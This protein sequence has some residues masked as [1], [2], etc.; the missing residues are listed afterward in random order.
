MSSG[1]ISEE[2]ERQLV[3][4]VELRFALA[5]SGEKLEKSLD[6]FVAPLLLKLGSPHA[7]VRQ[8][9]FNALKDILARLNSLKEVKVPAERLI[10]QAQKPA[11]AAEQDDSSIRLY[12]LLLASRGIDRMGAEELKPLVPL[13]MGG[14][15]Q[16]PRTAAARM[17]HI[18]CKILLRWVPPLKGSREEDEAREFLRLEDENDLTFLLEKFTKFYLLVPA[19]PDSRSGTIP[20]GYSCPGLSSEDVSFLTYEAGVS[21]TKEQMLRFK[22]AIFK[23]I[24]NGFAPEDILLT[25]FLLVASADAS[26]ISESAAQCLK[27]IH[28]PYEDA[29]FV[30]SIVELYTGDKT[31]GVPPVK[32]E[33][34]E[35]I[36]RILT[37]SAQAT[38]DAS[39]VSLICSIGMH[40]QNHKTRALC[41]VF[42]RHVARHNYQNLTLKQEN[43]IS[44][45]PLIR[46]NLHEEGWPRLQLGQSTPNFSAAIDRRRLEYE[47]LGDILRRDVDLLP[48][49]SY[50]EFLLDS[51][52]GDL[53]EF[54]PSIQ[55]ALVSLTPNL[56]L[57]PATSKAKLKLLLRKMMMDDAEL[58]YADDKDMKE[59]IMSCRYVGIKYCNA[60]FPF[61]D[62]E[63]RM[64][65]VWGT[66]RTNKFDVIEEAYKGLHPYWFRK[67]QALNTNEFKSTA[68]LLATE[69]E[70]TQLP[71][72]EDFVCLLLTELDRVSETKTSTMLQ[73]LNVAVRF[74]KQCLISQA[75]RGKTTMV[76][77]DEDWSV[78]IEKSLNIDEQVS[79]SVSKLLS[80]IENEWLLKFFVR[81]CAEFTVKNERGDQIGLFPYNDSIF[82]ETLITLLRF[83]SKSTLS[84]LSSLIPS[85]FKYLESSDT[86]S[87]ENLQIAANTLGIIAA[88][89]PNSESVQ[90]IIELTES[91]SVGVAIAPL[92]AGCYIIPRIILDRDFTYSPDV[93]SIVLG[94]LSALLGAPGQR[95]IAIGLLS[96]LTKYGSLRC[97]DFKPRNDFILEVSKILQPIL[98][99]NAAALEIWG[100]LSMYVNDDLGFGSMLEKFWET[101]VS[102]Q[103]DFLFSAGEALSVMAGGWKSRFLYQQLDLSF[104]PRAHLQ[105]MYTSRRLGIVLNTVLKNCDSTKPSS[106]KAS[107][108]WLLSLVQY[109]GN[110]QKIRENSANIHFKFMRF[111]AD[112]DEFIQ[113]SAARGLGLVYEMGDSDL[114]ETMVKG[115]MRSFTDNK[116]A[117]NMAAGSV[118]GDTELFDAGILNTG[119]GSVRTYKDI[120]NLAS[121]V[122]DPSLVYKFISLSKSSSLWSSK[123]GIS[124]GLGAIMSKSSLQALLLDDENLASKLIPKLFIYRFDPYAAVSR[125]MNDIWD[126]LISDASTATSR[127][128][129]IILKEAISGMADKEWR[130]RESSTLALLQLVQSQ[131][132]SKISASHLDIWTMAF[133]TMDDIKESVREAGTKLTTVLSKLL[134]RS[135]NVKEGVKLDTAEAILKQ[136]LP[137]FLGPKGF[138]SDAEEVRIFAMKTMLELIDNA[139][140]AI[141]PFTVSLVYDF[142]LLFSSIEPQAMNY[143]ALNANN[144]NIDAK[145]I[146][147]HRGNGVGKSS[148]MIAIEKLINDSDETLMADHVASAVKAVK[149]AVGLPSKVASSLVIVSLVK[150][151]SIA[152][153]PLT[154]KLLKTCVRSL[155]GRNH[156]VKVAFAKSFGH[157]FH[158][159][160]LEKA[161]KYSKQLEETY[162][163][164]DTE[165]KFAVA[166][167]IESALKHAPSEFEGVASILMPLLFLASNDTDEELRRLCENIWTEASTRGSGTIKLY[168]DEIL[169]LLGQHIGSSDF[170]MRRACGKSISV[171]CERIDQN[172]GQKQVEKLFDITIQSLSGRS[173]EGKETILS[174]LQSLSSKFSNHVS[175]DPELRKRIIEVFITEIS[176]KNIKYVRDAFFPTCDFLHNFPD[177][178][179]IGKLIKVAADLL[180][181]DSRYKAQTTDDDKE[182]SKRVTTDSDISKKSSQQNIENEVF[183]IKI[184]RKCAMI[185]KPFNESRSYPSQL[186]EFVVQHTASLFDNEDVLYTW[187][188]QV[189]AAEIGIDLSRNL[190]DWAIEANIK[191]LMA[192]LWNE[193]FQHNGTKDTIESAKLQTIKF[194]DSLRSRIADLKLQIEADL[195]NLEELDPTSRIE[196]ELRRI[197]I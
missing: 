131:P 27:R 99:K 85:L 43:N 137:F 87:N 158:V 30:N 123:K 184:L 110:E 122:G 75:T 95:N 84:S 66:R 191:N 52:K 15:S 98:M 193:V 74:S 10:V 144:F 130:V 156:S 164:S 115:L 173:W 8:A 114:K 188:S 128:F 108:I 159:T 186:L 120:L 50:I 16:L 117:M 118:S 18:L 45:A 195:R 129:D 101:H 196:T 19:R 13:V 59:G 40:S 56:P 48:D 143:L 68:D 47:T 176:R 49:L 148:L 88:S 32:P 104:V 106:R 171:L 51:L 157:V 167:A 138:N 38:S 89:T 153:R 152:L 64:L 116:E 25:K 183:H 151:F 97:L 6:T 11:V 154:G 141:K 61:D 78:R 126:S 73:S 65:N 132:I 9:V 91:A 134:A 2:K 121:D 190:A 70:E 96:Q 24:S 37:K 23:F 170:S 20:R 80:Q 124:F 142:T 14:I 181:K 113:Q 17:F 35:K 39:Q 3:E 46:N 187:R 54:R 26:V 180:A 90:K 58:N 71:S 163:S 194:A 168:L 42:I 100:Y 112:R 4:K 109:L 166:T 44:I 165:T 161:I 147:I 77:Q 155:Q 92:F 62:A 175:R 72:F 182:T 127:Y 79:D 172:I 94:K 60:V 63:A 145:A 55:E 82:G 162:F 34:Q 169:D 36:L 189:A 177:E 12:S 105:E 31:R 81:L 67:N 69:I 83:C 160:T 86:N 135:I 133:R 125:S 192:H 57:L 22:T 174:A 28:I 5:D 197:G 41:L 136:L 1:K 102:N 149:S 29:D 140:D 7:T 93:I 107:C 76:V 179:S 103:V 119:E 111:L 21:Y 178:K 53:P 33:L 139:G 146:D 150:K 185:C